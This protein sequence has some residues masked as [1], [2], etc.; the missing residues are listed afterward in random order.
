MVHMYVQKVYVRHDVTIAGATR[1]AYGQGKLG[2]SGDL[3]RPCLA[4]QP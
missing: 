2:F 3:A 1:V 4:K